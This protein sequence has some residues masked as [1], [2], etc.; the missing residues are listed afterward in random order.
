MVHIFLIY[1]YSLVFIYVYMYNGLHIGMC[2]YTYIHIQI[3]S[4][5]HIHV[6]HSCIYTYIYNIYAYIIF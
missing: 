5:T 4:H 3:C 1:Y 2:M 6:D